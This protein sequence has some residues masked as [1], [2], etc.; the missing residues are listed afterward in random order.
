MEAPEEE[1]L[2]TIHYLFRLGEEVDNCQVEV[3]TRPIVADTWRVL[4]GSSCRIGMNSGEMLARTGRQDPTFQLQD[5]GTKRVLLQLSDVPKIKRPGA[6]GYISVLG[7]VEGV[8]D[9]GTWVLQ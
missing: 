2:Q 8:K 9:G 6:M 4:D 5:S 1:G 3:V 7:D